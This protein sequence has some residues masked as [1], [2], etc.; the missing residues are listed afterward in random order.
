M[1]NISS[2]SVPTHEINH[3]QLLNSVPWLAS[4]YFLN[5]QLPDSWTVGVLEIDQHSTEVPAAGSL[6]SI[7]SS[8]VAAQPSAVLQLR[9]PAGQGSMARGGTRGDAAV[10]K[11]GCG[12]SVAH[13]VDDQGRSR[14]PD[15][16]SLAWRRGACES[17]KIE[18]SLGIA[19]GRCVYERTRGCSQTEAKRRF[20]LS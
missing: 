17:S 1:E 14:R 2:S 5:K 9:N 19:C 4:V 13:A 7:N 6:R 10:M 20:Q 3:K 12:G 11:A 8:L 16:A 18:S 15:V